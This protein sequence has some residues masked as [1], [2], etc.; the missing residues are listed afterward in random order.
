ME[1]KVNEEMFFVENIKKTLVRARCR[2]TPD[3]KNKK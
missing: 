2:F 3:I 1:K